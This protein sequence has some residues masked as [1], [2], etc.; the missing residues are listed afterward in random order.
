MQDACCCRTLGDFMNYLCFFSTVSVTCLDYS[1]SDVVALLDVKFAKLKEV[2]CM[3][4]E[5]VFSCFQILFFISLLV[6][7]RFVFVV[8]FY[9]SHH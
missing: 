9:I 4:F 8:L 5:H 3:E 2:I 1:F 6:I 7:I